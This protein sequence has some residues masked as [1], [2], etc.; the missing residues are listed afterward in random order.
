MARKSAASLAVI[1]IGSGARLACPATLDAESAAFWA[2]IVNSVQPDHFRPADVPLLTAYCEQRALYAR[3]MSHLVVPGGL[4]EC[5]ALGEKV[6]P[7]FAIMARS[8]QLMTM[9]ARSLRLTPQSRSTPDR[10]A[11]STR[12][13]AKPWQFAAQ[14]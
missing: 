4:T 3:A 1:P 12:S 7:Y 5:T 10:A 6:S 9:L 8:A 13:T 14:S 2:E 11:R